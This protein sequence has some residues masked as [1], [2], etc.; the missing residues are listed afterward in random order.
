MK[1]THFKIPS[2]FPG[3]NELMLILKWA[4]YVHYLLRWWLT[5]GWPS[6]HCHNVPVMIWTYSIVAS[7]GIEFCY[8]RLISYQ[9]SGGWFNV[10][11]PLTLRYLIFIMGIPILVKLHLYIELAHWLALTVRVYCGY[12][13]YKCDLK[14]SSD[15][16]SLIIHGRRWYFCS[17]WHHE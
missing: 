13:L 9:A 12:S 15:C 5:G 10:K 3:A 17:S 11:M 4:P 6:C 16:F 2:N 7:C 14:S 8:L 1:I